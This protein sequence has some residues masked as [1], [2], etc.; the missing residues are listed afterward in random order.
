MPK[1]KKRHRWRL[2]D[3]D[4]WN[5]WGETMPQDPRLDRAAQYV[6]GVHHWFVCDETDPIKW[7]LALRDKLNKTNAKILAASSQSRVN[8]GGVQQVHDHCRI[9]AETYC[10]ASL[11]KQRNRK[12]NEAEF[13]KRWKGVMAPNNP[14]T[15]RKV[16]ERLGWR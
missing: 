1:L 10:W 12:P 6:A 3:E 13:N 5:F 7:D 8:D 2:R 11:V 4:F 14:P 16:A 9:D 15:Y